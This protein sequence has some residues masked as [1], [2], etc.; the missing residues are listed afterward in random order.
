MM[1]I[2]MIWAP[3]GLLGRNGLGDKLVWLIL[4]KAQR[5]GRRERKGIDWRW[6]EMSK[7]ILKV[8]HVSKRFGG[9][10][11]LQDINIEVQEGEIFGIIGPNGAGKTT[12]FNMITGFYPT[13]DG[14][15]YFCDEDV[16]GKSIDVYCKKGITRT[17]QNIR[18]FTAMTVLNNLMVGM[19]NQIHTHL[20]DI[21]L[22]TPHNKKVE[23]EAVDKCMEI[24]DYL[25]IADLANN[26][27]GDLP[28]GK[29][30]KVEIARALASDPKLIL[31][32]EPTAGMNQQET[33]EL[34]ELIK[35]IRDRGPTVIVIEHNMRF[36][37]NLAERIAVLN[38]GELLALDTPDKIQANPEVIEAY[39][40]S[41]DDDDDF[42]S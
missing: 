13:T 21:M 7:T 10:K 40:G 25:G 18:T 14:K 5:K 42:A 4:R 26:L 37:M 38:F 41:K 39:L 8:D 22:S 11:A 28:Y 16:T 17:F 1:V 9:L 20:Y 6:S 34:A 23:K 19:H 12:L 27:A 3:N 30:R 31:L 36:M 15:I 2:M 35:G 24:L 29:Q 33:N 32:D